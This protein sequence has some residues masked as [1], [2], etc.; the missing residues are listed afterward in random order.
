MI[1]DNNSYIDRH[2]IICLG[3]N[4]NMKPLYNKLL[5]RYAKSSNVN[6]VSEL[7]ENGADVNARDNEGRTPL[8][9]SEGPG[10]VFNFLIQHGADVNARDNIGNSIIYHFN[11]HEYDLKKYIDKKRPL[12]YFLKINDKNKYGVTPLMHALCYRNGGNK[13]FVLIEKGANTNA[14]DYEGRTPLMYSLTW[15]HNF[16]YYKF[17]TCYNIYVSKSI[18][19]YLIEKGADV[20]AKDNNGMTPLMYFVKHNDSSDIDRSTFKQLIAKGADI[21]ARDNEGRSVVYYIFKRYTLGDYRLDDLL[22]SLICIEQA[23]RD[24]KKHR[25]Q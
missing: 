25:Y 5:L 12:P 13:A 11:I 7:L 23:T 3:N 19:Q 8:M 1:L 17:N 2:D 6:I 14:R 20:N 21:N 22:K 24:Q 9:I 10:N 4:D 18:I 16:Y 15:D